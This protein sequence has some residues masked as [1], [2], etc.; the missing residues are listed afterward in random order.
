MTE[1]ENV[2]ELRQLL[3][4]LNVKYVIV[5][6]NYSPVSYDFFSKAFEIY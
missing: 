5:N 3:I 4:Q 2:E 6:T 1:E